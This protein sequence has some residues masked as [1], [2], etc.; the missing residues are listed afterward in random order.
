MQKAGGLT[1]VKQ[2]PRQRM[3]EEP[4]VVAILHADPPPPPPPCMGVLRQTPNQNNSCASAPAAPFHSHC[5]VGFPLRTLAALLSGDPTG[6]L[7]HFCLGEGAQTACPGARARACI[8]ALEEMLKQ[9]KEAAFVWA[10]ARKRG[11]LPSPWQRAFE[12]QAADL[13]P[14]AVTRVVGDPPALESPW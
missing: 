14:L 2:D 13:A 10:P 6:Q 4:S 1:E 7:P 8:S 11:V 12:F 3:V 5:Y 9:A